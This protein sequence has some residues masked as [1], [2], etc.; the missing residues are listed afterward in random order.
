[1]NYLKQSH[2]THNIIAFTTKNHRS[3]ADLKI[4][5][6]IY[7]EDNLFFRKNHF[8]KLVFMSIG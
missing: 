8:G 2:N 6:I 1:M 7:I 3:N 5:Y 4:E